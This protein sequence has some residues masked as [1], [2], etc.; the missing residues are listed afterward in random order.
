MMQKYLLHLILLNIFYGTK[1]AGLILPQAGILIKYTILRECEAMSV[2]L[3]RKHRFNLKAFL[4]YEAITF[5]VAAVGAL[6]GGAN[7]FDGLNLPPLTPP[8]A[9][10]PVVWSILYFMMGLAAYLVWNSNDV[11]QGPILRLYL[12][13]LIV[14]GLWTFFFFRLEWRLFA[15]FWLLFLIALVTLTMA[16]FRH[17]R[18]SAYWLMV[19]YFLWILF[20]AYLN[21]GVYLL[22][23]N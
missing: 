18:R 20:A 17:I 11:D 15:F 14:N 10:F 2:T 3:V 4:F 1:P 8:A 21:L 5:A 23:K 16:G 7:G 6:L 13:Q 19:P 12:F 9:V 22:N